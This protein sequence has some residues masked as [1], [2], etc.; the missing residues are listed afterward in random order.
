M[1]RIDPRAISPNDVRQHACQALFGRP[2]ITNNFRSVIVEAMVA[3]ALGPEWQWC[4][5]DYAAWDFERDDGLRL[6]VKQSAAR[7]SWSAPGDRPNRAAFDIRERLHR[8]EG[9]VRIDEPGRYADLY[10][11]AYHDRCDETA[12]HG[13]PSQW[14]FYVVETSRLPAN[15]TISLSRVACLAEPLPLWEVGTALSRL[16]TSKARRRHGRL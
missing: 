11:F 12:D 16:A 7:Q 4:S 10:L 5:A 6:E 14:R 3:L 1:Y 13:D 2:L 9:A 8:Y 15:Q